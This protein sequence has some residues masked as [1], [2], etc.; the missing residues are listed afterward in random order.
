MESTQES[1]AGRAQ[2]YYQESNFDLYVLFQTFFFKSPRLFMA[3]S[4][5]KSFITRKS[6]CVNARGIPTA[7]YQ[8]LHLLPEVG[9]PGRGTPP[10][11]SDG[12]R[13][14]KVRYPQQGT[15]WQGTPSPPARS[16]RGYPRSGTPSRGN[17]PSDLAGVPPPSGPGQGTPP[18]VDR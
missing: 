12:G 9:P 5:Q 13:V 18:G 16:D 14:P 17:P 1:Q 6:S 8:V 11:R 2:E 10:A 15:P 3:S 4:A 7:A